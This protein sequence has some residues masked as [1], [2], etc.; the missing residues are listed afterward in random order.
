MALAVVPVLAAST[1]KQEM[2]QLQ[3]PLSTQ[4]IQYLQKDPLITHKVTFT[5]AQ[6]TENGDQELGDLTMG[7][8]GTVVPKTVENF[9]Q[10]ANMTFGYGYKNSILHRIISGFMIQGGDFERGVGTGGHSIYPSG[11]FID[12]NF[13]LS[14]NKMGRISMANSGP[15][16]N[17][18]Q[19]FIT[20]I[21]DNTRLDG[22]HVVFGQLIG[23]FDALH[24]ISSV[25]TG[26]MDRPVE[27]VYIKDVS[28][29]TLSKG[30]KD[31]LRFDLVPVNIEVDDAGSNFYMYFFGLL[32]LAG[33]FFFYNHWYHKKQYI[34][35]IK[36]SAYF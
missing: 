25:K 34:T 9:V 23:G 5:V 8:F 1:S 22:V 26:A 12:E 33:C 31:L 11:K 16:T 15:N 6:R 19:F 7:M 4:E 13:E 27:E 10:L 21:E 36:D 29:V 32:L 20:N 2:Q 3:P 18:A 30:G 28:V 24:K 14:H 17:G 35:D